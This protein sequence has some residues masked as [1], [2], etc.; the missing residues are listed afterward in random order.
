LLPEGQGASKNAQTFT[1]R[2]L[3]WLELHRDA[4][5]FVFLHVLDPHPPF[6]TYSPYATQWADPAWRDEQYGE[7][8]KVRP[9]ISSG[10]FRLLAMAKRKEL[11][12]AGIDT[13]RFVSRELDWY[14]GSILPSPRPSSQRQ[15]NANLLEFR[16]FRRRVLSG[17]R[18][19]SNVGVSFL[20]PATRRM[21]SV[22]RSMKRS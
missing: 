7:M 1:D 8:D 15:E 17:C 22:G 18:S 12:Q 5:F 9:F 19:Y 4:P 11:E 2:L 13:E 21:L 14:D 16:C 6:E 20:P 10:I 3:P